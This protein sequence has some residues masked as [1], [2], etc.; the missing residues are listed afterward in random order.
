MRTSGGFI[1]GQQGGGRVFETNFL[2]THD[3]SNLGYCIL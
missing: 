1:N 3:Y 2:N